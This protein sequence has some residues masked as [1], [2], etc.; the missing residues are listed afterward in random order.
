MWW[1]A[2]WGVWWV[3]VFTLGVICFRREKKIGI[4]VSYDSGYTLGEKA[5]ITTREHF[6][7]QEKIGRN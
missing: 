4:K 2:R 7:M 3:R 1:V 5:T 6:K